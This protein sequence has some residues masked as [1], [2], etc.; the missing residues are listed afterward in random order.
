MT[1]KTTPS[2]FCATSCMK[3]WRPCSK[4]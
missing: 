1:W 2:G 3:K 4:P